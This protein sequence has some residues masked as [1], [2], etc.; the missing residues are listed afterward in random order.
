MD[1]I[2]TISESPAVMD[3]ARAL[4][5]GKHAIA[6]GVSGSSTVFVAGAVAA[7]T[8]RPVV[9]V[10]AHLDDADEALEELTSAGRPVIRLP[11][12]E[13][14]PGEMQVN[15]ELFAE[16]LAA[17][18]AVMQLRDDG[19]VQGD[20]TK[21]PAAA[22]GLRDGE[23]RRDRSF[24]PVIVAPIQALMQ[25]VPSPERLP[26]LAMSVEKG[27][28]Y[29]LSSLV[30]WLD[31]AGYKR[32]DAAEEPG[33]F[34]VRGGILDVFPAG[35]TVW[36]SAGS[37]PVSSPVR[38]DFFGDEAEKI[39]EVDPETMGSGRALQGVELVA[40]GVELSRLEEGSVNF[41]EL[42]PRE[43]LAIVAETMEVTEQGRG[44]YERVTDPRGIFG[45]PAVLK[46]LKE[47]LSGLAE[48]N[49]FSAGSVA[50]DERVELPVAALHGFS[51]DAPE[52]V[53]ELGV[54]AGERRVVVLCQTGGE[55]QRFQEL[56]AEFAPG[57]VERIES[58]VQYVHRGFVW[59][60]EEEDTER[61]AASGG[62]RHAGARADSSALRLSVSSSLCIVPYHE[63]LHRFH[64]RR[65]AV[66]L[67]SG[68][69]MDTFLEFAPGDFVVHAE[70]GIAR[71]IGLKAMK[72]PRHRE[73]GGGVEASKLPSGLRDV[74][75]DRGGAEA[76]EYLTLEFAGR[77]K[78]HVPAMSIDQ[79]QKYI[80]GFHG[81]PQ[82]STLGG[83]R[84]KTQKE[85]VSESVRDLAAEM[86]RVRAAREHMPGVRYPADTAW[87][88]EFEAEF[89]YEETE[90][91]LAALAEIKKD[92]QTPRPMDRLVCG[93]VGFG[94]TELAI[95][96]AFKAV[97][98]G[99]QAAVLVPTTVLAEQHERTFR[100]RFSGYPFRIESLS[101]FKTDKD[102][103][104]ILEALRK[105]HV[106][107]IVGTHRLLSEDVKFADLG[108]VIVDEEQRFGVEHK[109][110]LLRLRLTVDVLTLSATPIPR[111]LHMAML[112]LRDISSL[113][114]PPLDRR[115]IVTE[116][117]PYNERRLAQAIARE[118]SRE[119]Q[120]FF[121]HNRVH[122]IRS[123]AD[124]VQRLAPE[125][126]IVVGHG[127]MNPH[128]L[129]E[130]MLRFMR[131]QADI[132]VSTTIIES[133]IDIPTANTM[134]IK[135]ADRFG[136]AELHQLRGRVGRYKHRAYC[137]MLLPSER[138]I[139]E[140]AQ[141][142][143][144]AIEQY[145]MLG[146]GFKIAMRDLEIRGA[147]NLLGAE[148]SGHIAA[149]GYEMYCRLLDE[150]VRDLKSERPPATVSSAGVE[151]GIAG[152]IPKAYIAS[153]QR[154]MEAYR[155]IA[156]AAS[157]EDLGRVGADLEEAYG[158]P[159][160]AVR[161]LLD[162]AEVR[163]AAAGLGVRTITLRGSD[164]LFRTDNPGPLAERLRASGRPERRAE[165]P[166]HR[167]ERRAGR[168][169]HRQPAADP[170][171]FALAGRETRTA[172]EP[173]APVRV[174]PP[175][176]G[177]KLHEVYLR[178]P[179]SYLEPETL[180]AVLRKRLGAGSAPGSGGPGEA[181][182]RA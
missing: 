38:I 43:A 173:E 7:I 151:I 150:A 76:Q 36:G 132:L 175:P 50:A 116:V 145:S 181:G 118:L 72:P 71:F 157:V 33:D 155:R 97:E 52:A 140:V 164:V 68:R 48:M 119:G 167:D 55:L 5:A 29:D 121:V 1:L 57:A 28:E 45:P 110:R 54:L 169:P 95:R 92:M 100:S 104:V 182:L 11:G 99:K 131:R 146:A 78:L 42:V 22:G 141:K 64:T 115:A 35:G 149:V 147:G 124:D 93:D 44:Y 2:R 89:P 66:R 137:Y 144:K 94:K 107:V 70:H 158:E 103:K 27:R 32:V 163:V 111:T 159:P 91:Q 79:V 61:P 16:R 58:Q 179:P 84:W 73:I 160:R 12:L 65:R 21:R 138:T 56:V 153:D 130:V 172:P 129:E 122:D 180:L 83:Q 20:E 136:L 90:D 96:A 41:L 82:L 156:A 15:V 4:G 47:R 6:T 125:A 17:V 139:R 74:V 23:S 51:Q 177:E 31:R 60:G 8:G 49:Q 128:E 133:G 102:A 81:K 77:A 75:E 25:A 88:K 34:S 46:L 86:L 126:R 168:P 174:L 154:R 171:R 162:L 59:E 18:R 127:Q 114:T 63:L 109:E 3:L 123:V 53:R 120:V 101:R 113:S 62:L 85:R 176:A 143:L 10:V 148:Q 134:I 142:R 30:R 67:K 108:L 9:L 117:I 87:Q 165:S 69:A 19:A 166:P 106:D 39:T 80:G 24:A 112:G 161:R 14:L 135:D 170:N 40:A 26:L 98:F 178:V 152:T 37:G 105:G 13:V